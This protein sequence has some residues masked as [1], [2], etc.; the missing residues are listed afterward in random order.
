LHARTGLSDFGILGEISN[1]HGF[2]EIH[3]FCLN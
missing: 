1:D 3:I 2:V